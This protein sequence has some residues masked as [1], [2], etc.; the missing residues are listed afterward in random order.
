MTP[1]HTASRNPGGRAGLSGEPVELARY[2]IPEGERVLVGRRV[3]GIAIVVDIPAGDEGRVYLVERDV[4]RDGARA[5]RALLADYQAVAE[6]RQ[7]V[8]MASPALVGQA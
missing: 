5:L 8:P 7:T 3:H 6:Q 1:P 4:E 2:T